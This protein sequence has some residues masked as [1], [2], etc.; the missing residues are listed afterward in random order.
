MLH[1]KL[2]VSLT[3][4]SLGGQLIAPLLGA[5]NNRQNP[6]ETK[7]HS[8]HTVYIYIY[9]NTITSELTLVLS[10]WSVA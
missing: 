7:V 2:Q 3:L 10:H 4:L 9:H 1:V 6:D 5:V 8:Q